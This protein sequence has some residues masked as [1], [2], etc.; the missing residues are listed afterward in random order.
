MMFF[1]W[2][3]LRAPV[4]Q[5]HAHPQHRQPQHHQY[6]IRPHGT[7]RCCIGCRDK[8]CTRAVMGGD[9]VY[10]PHYLART[11]PQGCNHLEGEVPCNTLFKVPRWIQVLVQQL[12]VK[13]ARTPRSA[14]Q[15]V[16]TTRGPREAS[17]RSARG[18]H[19]VSKESSAR[20]PQEVSMRSARGQ[21]ERAM[22]RRIRLQRT[23]LLQ[24]LL[25]TTEP[26]R[27]HHA[28]QDVRTRPVCTRRGGRL[29]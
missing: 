1:L 25:S 26:R 4:V 28:E 21:Q 13:H 27:L 23:V 2:M 20:G 18:R 29:G 9:R 5:V 7:T 8:M 15:E 11:A 14:R 22:G 3:Y 12:Q 24:L 16:R 17:K 10:Q 19:E 6:Q